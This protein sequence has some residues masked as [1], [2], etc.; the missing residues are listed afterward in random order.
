LTTTS[1][2]VG[3]RVVATIAN[4][5]GWR[6]DMKLRFLGKETESGNPPTLYETDTGMY[7]VQGW[8]ISDPE[9]LSQLALPEGES[10][11]MVPKA[12]MSHLPGGEHGAAVA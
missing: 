6:Q 12:L 4:H 3:I 11:V 5:H 10:A 1:V 2:G 7:V 8:V 9:A